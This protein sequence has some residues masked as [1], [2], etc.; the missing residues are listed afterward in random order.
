MAPLLPLQKPLI[1]RFAVVGFTPIR[2]ATMPKP[3]AA[4]LSAISKASGAVSASEVKPFQI[5]HIYHELDLLDRSLELL[6]YVQNNLAS[7]FPVSSPCED[8]YELLG[9]AINLSVESDDEGIWNAY[10]TLKTLLLAHIK[11]ETT[12]ID[13]DALSSVMDQASAG[14]KISDVDDLRSEMI[15]PRDI[16]LTSLRYTV[17]PQGE[18]SKTVYSATLMY[19]RVLVLDASLTLA[20]RTPV[21]RLP[22][23]VLR[24]PTYRSLQGENFPFLSSHTYD[25]AP[26]ML[27]RTG[28]SRSF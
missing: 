27:S 7:R 25:S 11:T 14:I 23:L 24:R 15:I 4:L 21:P 20:P 2:L 10:K 5:R 3:S 8:G 13:K 6:R 1:R 22:C 12:S 9:N 19:V 16:G 26:K 18:H 17:T 28:L